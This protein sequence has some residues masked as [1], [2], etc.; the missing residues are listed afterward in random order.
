MLLLLLKEAISKR[1][2]LRIILMSATIDTKLYKKYFS[3][4]NIINL[5]GESYYPI[6][7]HYLEY[8]PKQIKEE[9]FNIVNDICEK[10]TEGDILCFIHSKTEAEDISFKIKSNIDNVFCIEVYA[11]MNKD[12]EELATD[13]VL[14][15]NEGNY[16]RK[17]VL[18]TNVAESSLTIDGIKYII[19]S[20][21]E[22]KSRY[23]NG[24]NYLERKPIT[25]A[26]VIQ[27][28]GRAGRKAPGECY[29]LYSKEQYNKFNDFPGIASK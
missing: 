10:T 17:I 13:P 14:Y 28:K 5:T 18:A 9:T 8:V 19:E 1:K 2:D 27:R 26:Q 25:Q 11:G 3:K 22:L 6:K 16:D 29:H 20:G 23:E 12:N 4:L 21:S 7:S 24:I 15:K